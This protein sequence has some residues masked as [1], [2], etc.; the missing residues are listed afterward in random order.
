[1][2]FELT[3]MRRRVSDGD[4]LNDLRTV[5]NNLGKRSLKQR[6][7]C[8]KNGAQ[9]NLKTALQRFGSWD[10]T[11]EIA[12]LEGE[13]SL[14]GMEYGEKEIKEEA[15]LNDLIRVSEELHKPD[16]TFSDYNE[17]GKYTSET[18]RVRFGSWNK[19]KEKAKL[20]VSKLINNSNE[21]LFQN[22]VELWTLLG[23]QPKYGEVVSPHSKFNGSTYARR[24]GSW[25]V[26]LDAFIE[27][28]NTDVDSVQNLDSKP[29]LVPLGKFD[30]NMS[31]SQKS[32]KI[33]KTSRNI[34]LRMRWTILKRDNFCC[35]KCGNSPA[36]NPSIILHVDHILPWSR[37]GETIF[38][39]LETL[40][41]KCNLGKSN[42]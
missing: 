36:K 18:F 11:L 26:A 20:P 40:C 23:R 35:R 29:D 42:L 34:N 17:L 15:L 39:N 22:I 25:R 33:K 5:A 4:L 3:D 30:S 1:M 16:L 32:P 37:G 6:D 7:Y 28:V 2:K 12:G 21:E 27:Y 14:K 19:A 10:A 38:E 31:P 8:K 13:K 41:E 24:F 9:F